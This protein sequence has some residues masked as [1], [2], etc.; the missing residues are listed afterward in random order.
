MPSLLTDPTQDRRLSDVHHR[1][2]RG[3]GEHRHRCG[4][5]Q[6]ECHDSSHSCPSSRG[7][8]VEERIGRIEKTYRSRGIRQAGGFHSGCHGSTGVAGR[9]SICRS[10]RMVRTL[11]PS[12]SARS[13][14]VA[15]ARW[16]SVSASNRRNDA[17]A[18]P[19]G[20][21]CARLP[22]P[23]ASTPQR[24]SRRHAAAGRSEHP[25]APGE[26]VVSWEP[27]WRWRRQWP[28]ARAPGAPTT[29]VGGQVA[30]PLG[31]EIMR[32]GERRRRFVGFPAASHTTPCRYGTR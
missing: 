22:P 13:T 6:S 3:L 11:A 30:Q 10:R 4:K 32:F 15:A 5:S 1:R 12:A 26:P 19:R 2:E 25:A 23:A 21:R 8:I 31:Q 29:L 20:R 14:T 28:G 27:D 7:S 18:G 17:G 16:A 9:R 24:R